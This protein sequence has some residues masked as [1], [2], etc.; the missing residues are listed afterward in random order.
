MVDTTSRSRYRHLTMLA[1]FV[2]VVA[3]IYW[4]RSVLIPL[5]LAVLLAFLLNPLVRWLQTRGLSRIPAV[6][7]VV[8]A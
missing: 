6:I 4:A 8:V 5:A 1:S 3:S 7:V 2:L